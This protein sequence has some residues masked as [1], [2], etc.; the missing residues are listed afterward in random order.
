MPTHLDFHYTR[1]GE[2]NG[3]LRPV[4]LLHGSGRAEDDLVSFGQAVA[5]DSP[6]YALRG[7]VPWENGFAFFRRNPDRTLDYDDLRRRAENLCHFLQYVYEE[8]KHRPLLVGYSNGA[9]IAAETVF[10]HPELSWG[11][12]F[13]RP[14][15]PRTEEHFP[16]LDGYKTLIL[17][18]DK[19]DRRDPSDAPSFAQRLSDADCNV[20]LATLD[21]GH[22][23]AEKDLDIITSKAW[24]ASSQ[25][26]EM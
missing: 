13:L 9:I 6:I 7:Q 16:P 3:R 14:L 2:N 10:Q 18:G 21:A 12:I 23:W 4:V 8:T 22:G 19:D 24:L 26:Y 15:S 5:A 25:F 17:A 1:I 11:A 20:Q